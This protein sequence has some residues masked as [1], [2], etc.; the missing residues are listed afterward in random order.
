[1]ETKY[2]AQRR[3]RQRIKQFVRTNVGSASNHFGPKE[4]GILPAALPKPV[5][6]NKPP[7]TGPA[8]NRQLPLFMEPLF[9]AKEFDP[10]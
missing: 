7:A 5:F 3:Q 9:K 10:L 1:M 8:E 4:Q 2:A 6:T